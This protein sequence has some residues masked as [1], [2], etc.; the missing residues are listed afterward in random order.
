MEAIVL[1]LSCMV[2]LW[3]L[4]EDIRFRAVHWPLFPLGFGLILLYRILGASYPDLIYSTLYN[5]FFLLLNMSVLYLVFRWKGYGVKEILNSFIGLGDLLFFLGLCL[6][7]PFPLFPAF[8]ILS[9][10]LS[11]LTGIIWFKKQSIPLAGL[12]AL[13]LMAV[14]VYEYS[15]GLDLNSMI[16][17][18][19]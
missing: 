12:Q 1:I 5:F 10:I 18:L 4:F 14:L 9:L 15:A 7:L 11:L 6:A 19:V 16:L 17:W 8:F 13:F 3:V 2:L